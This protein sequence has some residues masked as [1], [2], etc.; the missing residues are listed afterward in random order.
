MDFDGSPIPCKVGLCGIAVHQPCLQRKLERSGEPEA[1]PSTD[2]EVF[3]VAYFMEAGG[4][5]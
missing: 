4:L 2:W 1:G 5:H 3:C